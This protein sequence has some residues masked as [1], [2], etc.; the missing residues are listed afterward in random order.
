MH[1]K[2]NNKIT[3]VI[4]VKAKSDR[5]K[6]KNL[7]KFADTNLFE[8]K[9]SQLKK[10]KCFDSFYV[11]SE[12]P[13][14]L[15]IAKKH[16]FNIHKRD[17]YYSTSKVPMSEVYKNIAT[18]IDAEHIAWIN[19]TNPLVEAKIYDEAA[20]KY[21][22][23]LKKKKFDCL[24]SAVENRENYFFKGKTLNFKRS[25]WPRSQDLE[26]LISLPFVISIL[27]KESLKKWRSCVGRKPFFYVIDPLIATDI[28]NYHNFKFCEVLY[29]EKKKYKE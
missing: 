1:S 15:K 19:I 13:E 25:P 6:R 29:E 28:D 22:K 2:L 3:G 9:L 10:T 20:K 23:N 27:K 24:L 5:V 12:S 4:P 7:R 8:L 21:L 26:P 17:P 16:G 18:E 11:S 14:V